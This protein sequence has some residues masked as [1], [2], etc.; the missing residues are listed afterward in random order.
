MIKIVDKGFCCG[1]QACSQICPKQCISLKEDN[2]GFLYPIVDESKCINCL[3]CEKV[4]PFQNEEV[5]NV[6]K[7][8]FGAYNYNEEERKRSSSGGVFILLAKKVLS[9][10]GVVFGAIFDKSWN[11]KH[12][13]TESIEGVYPMLQSKYVQSDI[14]VT[15][16][17]V[18]MFLKAGR[19]VLYCG[20]PCQIS[21]L[22][23][24]LCK[25]YDG[26]LTVDFLCHGV[27]SPGV[28]R[29]Y[30]ERELGPFAR[31][32]TAG[33]N[34]VLSLSL[35]TVSDLSDI[36]FRDKTYR[37]WKKYSF[38]VRRKLPSK[39]NKNTVLLSD[40]HYTNPYMQGFLSDVFLRPSCYK[41]KCK[42]GRSRSDLTLGDF[43][44]AE[45]IDENID[46]DKGL[47]LLLVN[48]PDYQLPMGIY[49]KEFAFNKV[50]YLN[51]GF[52]ESH[53]CDTIR[54]Y[55]FYKFYTYFKIKKSLDYSMFMSKIIKKL[56]KIWK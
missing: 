54:R 29:K 24:F 13:Y 42:N 19:K 23:R 55:F 41:C 32:A 30:V 44:C 3:L 45:Q 5:P 35:N 38:V 1:C 52:I 36:E 49:K 2:E 10:G 48:N 14:G 11:V 26:L 46:D 27:P 40:S 4:C 43:W 39:G 33:K 17:E 12:V 20:T 34:S 28:W 53:D 16:K 6:P 47:S 50:K 8:V 31:S 37:G 22:K 18:K 56:L 51:G 9:S 25:K 21:G 15:Y 7:K